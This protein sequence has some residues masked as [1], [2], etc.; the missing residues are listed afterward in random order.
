[1]RHDFNS[2]HFVNI[3]PLSSNLLYWFFAK[4]KLFVI[5][6]LFNLFSAYANN[7]LNEK[8][9]ERKKNTLK[10]TFESVGVIKISRK[11]IVMKL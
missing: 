9:R 10:F 7:P 3:S 11:I 2:A 4:V 6:Q 5:Q 1:M 8:E